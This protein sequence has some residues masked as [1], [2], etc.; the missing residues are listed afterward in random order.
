MKRKKELIVILS[1]LL[2]IV[3]SVSVAYF[4]IKILGTEKD[5]TVT[6]VD[7]KVTFTNGSGTINETSIE[8]GCSS[9]ENTFTVKNKSN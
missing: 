6:A 2:V 9:G 1:S 5:I 3:L 4:T 7:L 8:P